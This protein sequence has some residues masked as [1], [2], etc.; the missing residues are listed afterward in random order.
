MTDQEPTSAE[1]FEKL[2]ESYARRAGA[3]A[4]NNNPKAATYADIANAFAQL[5][6]S[7]R[8]AALLESQAK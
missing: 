6:M 2:A 3:E 7:K 5:A 8:L 1:A 4:K